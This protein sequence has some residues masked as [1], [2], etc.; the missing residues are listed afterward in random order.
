MKKQG[1]KQGRRTASGGAARP[2]VRK[3]TCC[4]TASV[5][6]AA[7][8]RNAP[9]TTNAATNENNNISGDADT[10]PGKRTSGVTSQAGFRS[11]ILRADTCVHV[12]AEI[13]QVEYMGQFQQEKYQYQREQEE[14]GH[15]HREQALSLAD[16]TEKHSKTSGAEAHPKGHLGSTHLNQARESQKTRDSCEQNSV[17]LPA[18]VPVAYVSDQEAGNSRGAVTH[19]SLPGMIIAQDSYVSNSDLL[20]LKREFHSHLEN[21]M[22]GHPRISSIQIRP[23]GPSAALHAGSI[24]DHSAAPALDTQATHHLTDLS[25]NTIPTTYAPLNG[26]NSSSVKGKCSYGTLNH[27]VFQ[28]LLILR[29]FCHHNHLSYVKKASSLLHTKWKQFQLLKITT[30]N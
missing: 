5:S 28:C 9:A 19:S 13:L 25:H 3:G 14:H 11:E 12:K 22:V 27:A 16:V 17:S 2:V 21:T 4:T 6:G 24:Q 23:P 8:T 20:E 29:S 10:H 18:L 7:V 15:L 1:G 26:A 30:K